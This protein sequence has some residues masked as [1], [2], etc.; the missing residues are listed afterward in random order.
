[1]FSGLPFALAP[2]LSS[3][4]LRYERE[5]SNVDATTQ[6]THTE[7]REQQPPITKGF[8]K[9]RRSVQMPGKGMG[10]MK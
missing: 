5:G 4:G 6:Q 2:L 9:K 10:V 8:P 3:R 1:M 7:C